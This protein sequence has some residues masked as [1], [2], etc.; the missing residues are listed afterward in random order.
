MPI[1]KDPTKR[2]IA[3]QSISY[4]LAPD[5]E[6]LISPMVPKEDVKTNFEAVFAKDY[7]NARVDY[8]NKQQ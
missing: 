8:N 6:T 5:D 1:P 2:N 7:Y 4:F 3:R